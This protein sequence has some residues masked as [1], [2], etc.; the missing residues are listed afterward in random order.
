MSSVFISYRRSDTSGWAG[1]LFDH[2][3]ETFGAADVFIDID[4]LRPGVPFP[5]TLA[6]EIAGCDAVL[7]LIGRH[8]LDVEADGKRRLDLDTDF[9]RL[10]IAHAI[11]S[12]KPLIPLLVDGAAMPDAASLPEPLRPL[13]TCQSKTLS[14]ANFRREVRDVSERVRQIALDARSDR[15]TL[16]TRAVSAGT[17][18]RH[19]R[20]R[21]ANFFAEGREFILTGTNFGDQMGDR[22]TPPG[23]LHGLVVQALRR[24]AAA[25]VYLVLAPFEMLDR[26]VP[27]STAD[28]RGRS[29]ARLKMLRHDPRLTQQ[30]RARL[31]I[32]DHRGATFLS[33]ALRDPGNE[34][35]PRGLAVVT[36]RWFS[37]EAGPQ[38][39]FFA[40]EQA[41]TPEI[42]N[43]FIGPIYP[44]IKVDEVSLAAQPDRS[45]GG[46]DIDQICA[47]LGVED[48]PFTA[49]LAAHPL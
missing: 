26:V 42:F 35:A 23:L 14:H 19:T 28:L 29:A 39:M 37:D 31:H 11:E 10:E 7:V 46:R 3:V 16:P 6:S 43:A 8:W 15:T 47:A 9:V 24:D 4:S 17:E 41:A 30:E 44:R 36:P 45:L 22:G 18:A 5:E 27:N 13:A 32:F 38:R 40:I 34:G 12:G 21:Y 1:R 49:L 33:V 48:D 2:L 25:S 20:F